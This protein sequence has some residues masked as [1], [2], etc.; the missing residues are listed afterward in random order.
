[1]TDPKIEIAGLTNPGL[2]RQNNE[3]SIGFQTNPGL[4]VLADGM[5]GHS[6]GEVASEM[7]VELML[8]IL[9][10]IS[11]LAEGLT[12]KELGLIESALKEGVQDCNF[13]I[14][15]KSNE[16]PECQGMGT[17]VVA[18]MFVHGQ[19]LYCHVGDSRLYRYRQG[20]LTQI[21]TDH[22]LKQQLL[23]SG[24]I[25]VDNVQSNI[26]TQAL[27]TAQT[28]KPES[29]SIIIDKDDIFLF[30][31]D[32]LTDMAEDEAILQ[33]LS[34]ST[35]TLQTSAERLL[36]LAINNGGEDNVS[37]VLARVI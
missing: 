22:S 7:A 12:V 13:Q 18:G 34:N 17:T 19:L 16:L 15:E 3:D 6:K 10:E 20:Q 35:N 32:G 21:T 9:S 31:S 33:V 11:F 14:H 26:I 4:I 5:G 8:P 1:M 27:G 29:S 30:C 37:V 23:N 36:E 2:V 24:F 25:H 28:C